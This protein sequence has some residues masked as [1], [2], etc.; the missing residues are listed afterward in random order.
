MILL[1]SATGSSDAAQ[2]AMDFDV[3]MRTISETEDVSPE[4]KKILVRNINKLDLRDTELIKVLRACENLNMAGKRLKRLPIHALVQMSGLRTLEISSNPGISISSEDAKAL[5]QV[6]R[7]ILKEAE[8]SADQIVHIMEMPK[9]IGLTLSHADLTGTELDFGHA[10]FSK[11]TELDLAG[12]S[13]DPATFKSLR[14][15]RQLKVL[16]ISFMKTFNINEISFDVHWP[17]LVTLG[18]RDCG[19]NI[20]GF[21]MIAMLPDLKILRASDNLTLGSDQSTAPL[22]FMLIRHSLITLDISNCGLGPLWLKGIASCSALR[23]LNISYNDDILIDLDVDLD[24]SLLGV[25]ETLINLNLTSTELTWNRLR[26]FRMCRKIKI[27]TAEM[28]PSLGSFPPEQFDFGGMIYSLNEIN[29]SNCGLRANAIAKLCKC[30]EIKVLNISDNPEATTEFNIEDLDL[31]NISATVEILDVSGTGL[32]IELFQG[33]TYFDKLRKLDVSNN[34]L[35]IGDGS[36]YSLNKLKDTLVELK[37]VNCELTYEFLVEIGECIALEHLEISYNKDLM[38]KVKDTSTS[39]ENT[40]KLPNSLLQLTAQGCSLSYEF[41]IQVC[42]CTKLQ[43]INLSQNPDL[44]RL[45]CD[46][47]LCFNRLKKT[48]TRVDLVDTGLD[49]SGLTALG[50]CR[51]IEILRIDQNPRVGGTAS[52]SISFGSMRTSLK[53][54]SA[55]NMDMKYALFRAICECKVLESL[56][57][58]DNRTLGKQIPNGFSFGPLIHSLKVLDVCD[59][60]A[61]HRMLEAI[62]ECRH[63]TT[64]DIGFN[65]RMV[66]HSKP[67]SLGYLKDS[68]TSLKAFNVRMNHALLSEICKCKVLEVL[69][70]AKN[71]QVWNKVDENFDFGELKN[72]LVEFEG[73]ETNMGSLVLEKFGECRKLQRLCIG[74]NKRLGFELY[75]GVDL[76]HLKEN[77]TY[78]N[79]E[80]T[81][82]NIEGV[83]L[84]GGLRRMKYLNIGKNFMLSDITADNLDLGGLSKTLL[85]LRLSKF[86]LSSEALGLLKAKLPHAVI[87]FVEI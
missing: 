58:Y 67:I 13:M 26:P 76:G 16:D 14:S 82:L 87:T 27:L 62:A 51:A 66:K 57:M 40:F 52:D 43:K 8:V 48:L 81:N 11:L 65:R 10:M 2:V 19:L 30:M 77:L 63:I 21:N 59:T 35:T 33:L 85:S 83:R 20:E 7:V 61:D 1:V 68:M 80:N 72:T 79:L 41:I 78:L 71:K 70:I 44:M 84:L 64:L 50:E 36:D 25:K 4:A 45:P 6:T 39:A 3:V 34:K 46:T 23:T 24:F 37:A 9:L 74:T 53:L 54:L 60:N 75:G 49:A 86:G 28:N 55:S 42:Y 17:N 56:S 22:D 15:M 69:G 73:C 31:K 18:V 12:C 29:L 38:K 47:D 5:S 32:S